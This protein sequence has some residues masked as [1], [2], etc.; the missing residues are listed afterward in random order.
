MKSVMSF[1]SFFA[2]V[3]KTERGVRFDVLKGV[4]YADRYMG[5]NLVPSLVLLL[6]A[7]TVGT[8]GYDITGKV[9]LAASAPFA[10]LSGLFIGF[11]F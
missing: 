8:F 11:R 6:A 5:N 4:Q 7:I 10:I 1:L 2:P 3:V 9:L